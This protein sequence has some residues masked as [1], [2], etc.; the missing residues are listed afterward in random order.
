M[1]SSF[2]TL[3]IAAVTVVGSVG[4]ASK[5]ESVCGEVN[6]CTV[7]ER[8]FQMD[9]TNYCLNVESFEQ[10]AAEVGADNC[11]AQ[12]EEFLTCWQ[13]NKANICDATY[14]GCVAAGEAWTECLTV[15][16]A[17]HGV[18][19][20]ACDETQDYLVPAYAPF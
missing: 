13:N 20:H 5:C 12:F 14:E 9:C 8:E 1:K 4:C 16:C 11:S 3:F 7:A 18:G 17:A 2:L 6:T 10:R 19:D 15:Y